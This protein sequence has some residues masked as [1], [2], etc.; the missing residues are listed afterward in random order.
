MKSEENKNNKK[1]SKIIKNLLKYLK[2]FISFSWLNK[3]IKWIGN[4]LIAFFL[5]LKESLRILIYITFAVFLIGF[6][7]LFSISYYKYNDNDKVKNLNPIE[8][9]KHSF[10]YERLDTFKI[11]LG[12]TNKLLYVIDS[13]K[14]DTTKYKFDTISLQKT[15]KVKPLIILKNDT[16]I[17][18]LDNSYKKKSEENHTSKILNHSSNILGKTSVIINYLILILAIIGILGGYGIYKYVTE[19]KKLKDGVEAADRNVLDSALVTLSAVPFIEATQITS[20]EYYRAIDNITKTVKEKMDIIKEEPNYAPL[21]VVEALDNWKEGDYKKTIEVLEEAYKLAYKG[22]EEKTK[23][24]IAFH[25]ARA[26][27]QRGYKNYKNNYI[28]DANNDFKDCIEKCPSKISLY[29][30]DKV[31]ELSIALIKNTGIKDKLINCFKGYKNINQII[32]DYATSKLFL[33]DLAK[34]T[35]MTTILVRKD[36]WENQKENLKKCAKNILKLLEN[37]IQNWKGLNIKA[38]WYHTMYR[39]AEKS[40]LKDEKEKYK[41]LFKTYKEQAKESGIEY[42]LDCQELV[43]KKIDDLSFEI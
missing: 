30:Y 20:S 6:L 12:N 9:I 32:D 40:E 22:R 43:E 28:E 25:L 39:I 41:A 1:N 24:E 4:I 15:F 31:F 3:F 21:L 16:A 17:F 37:E 11:Y 33:S 29:P 10:Q 13:T 2:G 42:L 34:M 23:Q 26:Y 8:Y 27:K 35:A 14:N 7:T 36:F 19:F 18:L 5:W 38:S